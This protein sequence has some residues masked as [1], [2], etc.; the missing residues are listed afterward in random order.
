MPWKILTITVAWAAFLVFWIVAAFIYK[1][2]HSKQYDKNWFLFLV[3]VITTTLAA[4][5]LSAK[6]FLRRFELSLLFNYF[7][8]ITGTILIIY[9]LSFAIWARMTLGRFWSGSVA[10]IENQPIIKD[11]PYAIIRHPIY[12]GVISM[13]WGSFLLE[14]IGFMLFTAC[15]GTVFLI[16]KAKLEE[17]LLEKRLG[18]EYIDYKKASGLSFSICLFIHSIFIFPIAEGMTA[19]IRYMLFMTKDLNE[20]SHIEVFD[21]RDTI[22]IYVTWQDIDKGNH[23]LTAFWFNPKGKQ[24]EATMYEFYVPQKR[25]DIN[26]WLWLKLHGATGSKLAR[27]FNPQIGYEKFIGKWK[28]KLYLDNNYL[29]KRDFV[30]LC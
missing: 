15:L 9:G 20:R 12:T 13:L 29:T 8:D 6:Y 17:S 25:S 22:Y 24:Q 16:L 27:A 30:V 1:S 3:I 14:R 28:V 26:S 5:Y 11:G 4:T 10:Y 21:C 18:K 2:P 7:A 19:K 23:T